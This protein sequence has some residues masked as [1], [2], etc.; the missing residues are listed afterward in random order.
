MIV[1]EFDFSSTEANEF[2]LRDGD[3]AYFGVPQFPFVFPMN[4]MLIMGRA[5]ASAVEFPQPIIT[6]L[7]VNNRELLPRPITNIVALGPTQVA[8]VA[9][10]Q[11]S[12]PSPGKY[13]AILFPGV[14]MAHVAE[15]W[16]DVRQS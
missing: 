7:D 8:L 9:Q 10:I 5:M 13:H 6:I 14:Q 16:V 1:T 11:C 4:T 12:F 15:C 2:T 3:D